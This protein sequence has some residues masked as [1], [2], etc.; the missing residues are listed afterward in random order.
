MSLNGDAVL[1]QCLI[2]DDRF[3]NN[4][5]INATKVH[6]DEINKLLVT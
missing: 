4:N 5:L 3:N 2:H 1:K 6:P